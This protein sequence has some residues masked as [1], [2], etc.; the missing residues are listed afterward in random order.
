MDPVELAGHLKYAI[1]NELPLS[2]PH[3]PDASFVRRSFEKVINYSS[4]EGMMKVREEERRMAEMIKNMPEG[5]PF[6]PPE[7]KFGPVEVFGKARPDL[8]WVDD[9]K[10]KH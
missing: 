5:G 4:V 3:D 8:D 10:R 7:P 6:G 1:E 2:L 9:S